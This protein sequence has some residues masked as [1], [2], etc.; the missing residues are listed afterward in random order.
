MKAGLRKFSQKKLVLQKS[1]EETNTQ[2]CKKFGKDHMLYFP[3]LGIFIDTNLDGSPLIA[4]ILTFTH[5]TS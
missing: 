1:V 2:I 3:C 4:N 5:Y